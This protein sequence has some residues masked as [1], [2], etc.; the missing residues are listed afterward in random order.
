MDVR[1]RKVTT[2]SFFKKK[3]KKRIW[4][5]WGVTDQQSHVVMFA[6]NK[7]V[8]EGNESDWMEKRR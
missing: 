2:Y 8:E 6:E 4:D 7:E 1:E 5:C 3:K